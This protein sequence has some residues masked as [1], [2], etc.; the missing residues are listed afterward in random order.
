MK[1][2]ICLLLATSLLCGFMVGCGKE[3][4]KETDSKVS[5]EPAHAHTYSEWAVEREP[6]CSHTGQKARR[7]KCGNREMLLI[8]KEPHNFVAGTCTGCGKPDPSLE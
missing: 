6:T 3:E 8:P 1:K 5:S 4:K 7:C 2:F